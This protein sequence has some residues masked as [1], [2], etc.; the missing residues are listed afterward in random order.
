[1]NEEA[2]A[3]GGLLC[4]KKKKKKKKKISRQPSPVKI[5]VVRA[6]LNKNKT[7]YQQIELE[8]KELARKVLHMEHSFVRCC[9]S[10]T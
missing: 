4:K 2:L 10:D 3:I 7:F 9:I 1:M 5:A 8:F 6:K